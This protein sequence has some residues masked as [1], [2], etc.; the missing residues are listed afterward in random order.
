MK[1]EFTCIVCPV[2]CKLVVDGDQISGNRCPRGLAYALQEIKD[3]KRVV[4]TTVATNS[5]IKR[6]L[7]VKT[8]RPIAKAL[9]F[10]VV[11]TLRA[12]VIRNNIDVG[13]IIISNILDTDVNIVASDEFRMT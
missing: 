9:V 11:K 2:G 10:D 4:T 12:I 6:R 7:A 1:K 8:D 5:P 13:D 3:P